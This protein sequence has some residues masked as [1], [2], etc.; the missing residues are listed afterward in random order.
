[1]GIDV[2]KADDVEKA[3]IL[4]R[5]KDLATA[6]LLSLDRRRCGELILLLKK[7]YAK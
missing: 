1:M 6:F 2:E 5:S 7:Y 4:E 3:Q